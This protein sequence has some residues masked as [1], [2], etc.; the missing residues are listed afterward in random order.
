MPKIGIGGV[1]YPSGCNG[2][3]VSVHAERLGYF[4]FDTSGHAKLTGCCTILFSD[5]PEQQNNPKFGVLHKTCH[6]EM[7]N[8]IEHETSGSFTNNDFG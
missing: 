2:Y 8:P 5:Q 4:H 3:A 6:V 7:E 1:F